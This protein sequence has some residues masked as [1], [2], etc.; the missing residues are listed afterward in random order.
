MTLVAPVV[1]SIY[2][3]SLQCRRGSV[4]RGRQFG[5]TKWTFSCDEVHL[6]SQPLSQHTHLKQQTCSEISRDSM[7]PILHRPIT[8]AVNPLWEMHDSIVKDVRGQ[9][10]WKALKT[11]GCHL[12]PQHKI[13]VYGQFLP[14][15]NI[16]VSRIR[17][18]PKHNWSW[19]ECLWSDFN[20]WIVL[21]IRIN[22][23]V[24]TDIVQ[25]FRQ[26]DI[27]KTHPDFSWCVYLVFSWEI[28]LLPC[29]IVCMLRWRIM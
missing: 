24:S 7:A 13:E 18:N 9:W 5:Q 17:F 10:W 2:L 19:K 20:L 15:V 25:S 1:K 12:F 6:V 4:E 11:E 26:G 22:I 29:Y 8:A 23:Y 28:I 27:K 14:C 16:N 21:F 3:I